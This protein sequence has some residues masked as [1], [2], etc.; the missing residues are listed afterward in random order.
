MFTGLIAAVGTLRNVDRRGDDLVLRIDAGGLSFDDIS[1]GD[2]IAVNGVCLTVTAFQAPCF[3]ADVSS[4]TLRHSRLG[5][6]A[7]GDPVNLEK[8]MALGDRLGGHLVSG[9]VDG[10]G[11][12]RTVRHEGRAWR[13]LI[14]APEDLRRFIAARGSITVDGTSLTV[15]DLTDSGFWINVV[16]HTAEKTIIT[17]YRAGTQVHLEVDLIAR[18]LERLMQFGRDDASAGGSRLDA[19]FLAEHGFWR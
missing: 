11:I 4:E 15:N 7:A 8:A 18:Y 14:E 3:E 1:L 6:L 10:V 17:H 2:S 19:R 9:H 12:V 16:P 13:L 5:T